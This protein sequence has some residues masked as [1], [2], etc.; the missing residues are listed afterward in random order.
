MHSNNRLTIGLLSLA[1]LGG[2]ASTKKSA[3]VI[4]T[5]SGKM[6]VIATA[7]QEADAA[8]EAIDAANEH[9]KDKD[10]TAIFVDDQLDKKT[11]SSAG[12]TLGVIIRKI[13]VLGR[14]IASNEKSKLAVQFRCK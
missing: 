2:C 8:I 3:R 11:N 13:P 10:Q 1:L 12:K 6:E 14:T 7:N 9:C 4:Q 5:E